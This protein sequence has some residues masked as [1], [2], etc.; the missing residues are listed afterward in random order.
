MNAG[1]EATLRDSPAGPGL[2]LRVGWRYLRARKRSRRVSFVAVSSIAGLA[3]GV[4]VLITVLSIMNGFGGALR[5]R[6]L[7][8]VPQVI[9][10]DKSGA[11]GVPGL[12]AKLQGNTDVRDAAPFFETQAMV[13]HD[14][15]VIGVGLFGVDPAQE[16][17]VSIVPAH[18]VQGALSALSTDDTIMLGEPLAFHL[19]IVPGDRVTLIVPRADGRGGVQPLVVGLRLVA[20]FE[21]DAE[22]DYSIAFVNWR[23]P[24]RLGFADA[25]QYGARVKVADVFAAPAIATKLGVALGAQYSVRA[26]TERFG[27]LF[28]A[29]GMEKAMMGILLALV[30]TIASFNVVSSLV[31][32]VDEKR[33]DIAVLRTM[34]ASRQLIGRIFLAHGALI[35]GIGLGAGMVIG[36]WLAKHVSGA[37]RIA[38]TLTGAHL[39]EGTYFTEVPSEVLWSDVGLV[40]LLGLAVSLAAALYPARRAARLDPVQALHRE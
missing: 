29:V 36:V 6:I 30:V 8:S 17:K 40:S 39:L 18:V 9:V 19:G 11:G 20:T 35:A 24:T 25:G 12:L 3:L 32:L 1:G 14:G 21:V 27:A 33:G 5:E 13:M 34:G 26:W 4:A 23:T 31:M 7:G 38:E 37:I 28:Q 22:V 16:A 15:A 10:F 2:A